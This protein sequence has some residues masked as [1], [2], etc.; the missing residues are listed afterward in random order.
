MKKLLLLIICLFA[1]FGIAKAQ[2]QD[3]PST[4]KVYCEVMC[5]RYN[6]F[7]DDV[8]ANVDFGIADKAENAWGWIYNTETNKKMSFASP[9]SV[10]TY[11]AKNGWEYKDTI[12]VSDVSNSKGNQ[13]V[14]HFILTKEMPIDCTPEDIIGNIDYR[15]K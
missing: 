7:K 11:M 14:R 4:M 2:V 5:V 9:M 8:N 1:S 6:L 12:I 10:I 13:Y 15:N 3:S